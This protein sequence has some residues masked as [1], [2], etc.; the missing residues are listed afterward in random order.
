[1]D[2]PDEAR[3][4][5]GSD[6]VA[7]LTTVTD[8]GRPAPNPVWFVAAGENLVVFSEPASRRVHNIAVRP[9]VALHFNCDPGGGDV[10][11]VNGTAEIAHGLAPSAQPGYLDKYAGVITG[12]LGLTFADFDATY[13]TRITI[14]PGRVR[15]TPG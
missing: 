7:W 11:I 5:I 13:S 4:R 3:R 12:S 1:M 2:L 8:S 14:T 9:E 15:L 6:G 10:V